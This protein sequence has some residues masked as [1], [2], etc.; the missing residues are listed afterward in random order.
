MVIHNGDRLKKQAGTHMI[1][2]LNCFID[3]GLA[4][5]FNRRMQSIIPRDGGKTRSIR[6]ADS[7]SEIEIEDASH[8]IISGSD[9]SVNDDYPWMDKIGNAIE[10]SIKAGKPVLGICFGHQILARTLNGADCVSRAIVPEFGW[11]WIKTEDI[12]LFSNLETDTFM[13]SHYDC[14][15]ELSED[16]N[17]IATS[18]RC[19]TQAFQYKDLPVFG[20]QFHPEY[21]PDEADA[22]FSFLKKKDEKLTSYMLMKK[23]DPD[24]GEKTAGVIRNFITLY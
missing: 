2:I 13:V 12:P 18:G 5:A 14:V 22:V 10:N 24:Q 17:T 6:M 15:T 4:E 1:L 16:F 11:A 9:I 20:V 21:G 3:N 19:T 7:V 8:I 23:I